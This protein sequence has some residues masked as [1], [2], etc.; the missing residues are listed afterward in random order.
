MGTRRVGARKG[1]RRT[2]PR[3]EILAR[4]GIRAASM[5]PTPRGDPRTRPVAGAVCTQSVLPRPVRPRAPPAVRSPGAATAPRRAARG[6]GRR[7]AAL[8]APGRHRHPPSPLSA[9]ARPAA[10][11]YPRRGCRAGCGLEGRG[12]RGPR[13]HALSARS[14]RQAKFGWKMNNAG[15]CAGPPGRV[16]ASGHLFPG[17]GK[18]RAGFLPPAPSFPRA[19]I[20]HCQDITPYPATAPTGLASPFFPA[21]LLRGRQVL[22]HAAGAGTSAPGTLRPGPA[23][24]FPAIQQVLNGSPRL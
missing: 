19:G 4:L 22:G 15:K 21:S 18:C 12:R 23:F 16:S 3:L 7:R 24:L 8:T 17:V 9:S 2:P 5:P 11:P 20:S 14:S 10:L 6:A 1:S 13:G